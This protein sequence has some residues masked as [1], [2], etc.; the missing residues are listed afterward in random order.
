MALK[1]TVFD[2][3][4]KSFIQINKG[5]E[6]TFTQQIENIEATQRVILERVV[7]IRSLIEQNYIVIKQN[8]T[9]ILENR[10]K[11]LENTTLLKHLHTKFDGMNN[12]L[13][14]INKTVSKNNQEEIV[15]SN[16]S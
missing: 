11:I 3:Y 12:L 7:G 9:E 13:H 1:E 8:R 5:M 10:S 2:E 14:N 4:V 6:K 15:G 16:N